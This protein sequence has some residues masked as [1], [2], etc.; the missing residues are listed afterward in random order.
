MPELDYIRNLL[1]I[2]LSE[3]I[4]FTK[5]PRKL[6]SDGKSYMVFY[7]KLTH[8]PEVCPHCGVVRE[9]HNIRVHDY[10]VSDIKM[11]AFISGDQAR[12][13]LSKPRFKC[14]SCRKTFKIENGIVKPYHQISNQLELKIFRDASLPISETN[15]AYL[16]HVSHATVNRK[17]NKTHEQRV[18]N[19]EVLPEVLCFDEF[20]STNNAEGAM[21][22]IFK[23]HSG[24][25]IDIVENRQLEQLKRYFRQYSRKARRG[26]KHIVIDIYMPYVSLIETMFPNATIV[27]DKFHVVQLVNRALN[28]TKIEAMKRHKEH[29]TKFK[30]YWRLILMNS[31][32]LST[33]KY[34]YSRTFQNHLTTNQIV[35]EILNI[36]GELKVTNDYYQAILRAIEVKDEEKLK[37]LFDNPYDGISAKMQIAR[38]SLKKFIEPIIA[39][40]DTG[41]T[42]ASL[43]GTITLIKTIKRVAFGYRSFYHFRNRIM[44]VLD[45]NPIKKQ[46]EHKAKLKIKEKERLERQKS[47][48]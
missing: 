8:K 46:R 40:L 28:Q 14:L 3:K 18:I 43:V 21:S 39:A 7:A 44:L 16:N 4:I 15:I 17:I 1:G 38:R 41:Y 25:V 20:K 6:R 2:K 5:E 37:H 33:F 36:D 32:K 12:L 23:E 19:Y 35:K 42:N 48:A 22:F 13:H 27:I 31:S 26:V 30:N 24:K 9:G 45:Y 29:H 11:G 10:Y 34:H 47:V